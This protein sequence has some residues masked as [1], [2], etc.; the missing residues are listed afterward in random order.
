MAQSKASTV[1]E[2]LA[3]LPPERQKAIGA[4]RSVI[5][6]NLPEGYVEAMMFGMIGYGVSLEDY[7]V[8]YNKQPLMYAALASQKNYM[9]VY[10]MNVYGDTE[11]EQW[12]TERY[13]ASGKRLNRGKSCVR[14]KKTE[15]LPLELVGE[16]IAR[17]P[18]TEFIKLYEAS[19]R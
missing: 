4:V 6:D 12:F 11:T 15:D 2:Y 18:M 7:P 14:F 8:T 1:D 5:L 19:R 10:L 17:S 3:E 9:T 16:A 13:T